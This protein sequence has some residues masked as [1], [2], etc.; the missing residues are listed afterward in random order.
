MQA[1]VNA[2]EEQHR[3]VSAI[4]SRA[5]IIQEFNDFLH[6]RLA[7]VDD[8]SNV[9]TSKHKRIRLEPSDAEF[10]QAYAKEL[11]EIYAQTD[12]A[13]LTFGL[14]STDT[15]WDEPRRQWKEDGKNGYY[16]YSD[17]HVMPFKFQ[18]ICRSTWQVAQM[19]HR[20]EDREEFDG[21]E[22]PENTAAFKFRVTTCLSS[23][24]TV[25]VLQRAV[26]RRYVVKDRSVV[27]WR[28]FY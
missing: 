3:L 21:L 26:V 25:S 9:I 7:N 24:R 22:D 17:K 13:L 28:S 10:Y 14:D 6:N 4:E 5:S 27:V 20:Q 1:R 23:G 16:V 19:Q 15:S 2:E 12:T 11:D 18:Q 8:V